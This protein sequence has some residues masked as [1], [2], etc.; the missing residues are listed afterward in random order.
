MENKLKCEIFDDKKRLEAKIYSSV[1]TKYSNW[2]IFGKNLVPFKTYD[3]VKDEK[4]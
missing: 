1:I 4:R 3:D 2:D